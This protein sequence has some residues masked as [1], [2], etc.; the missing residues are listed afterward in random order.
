MA[1]CA[2][3]DVSIGETWDE[4]GGEGGVALIRRGWNRG[5][6]F[7][8]ASDGE[9]KSVSGRISNEICCANSVVGATFFLGVDVA[10]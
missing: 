7:S 2:R 3:A 1:R 9:G 4:G 5:I 8:A 6:G 10:N